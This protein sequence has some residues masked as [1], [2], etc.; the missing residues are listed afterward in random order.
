MVYDIRYINELTANVTPIIEPKNA[1]LRR[2]MKKF[3]II[4][5]CILG[6]TQCGTKTYSLESPTKQYIELGSYGGFAGVSMVYTFLSNGQR[7]KSEGLM[8]A[9]AKSQ[10]LE[11]GDD[12][13]F[14]NMLKE[15]K[16]LDFKNIELNEVG[17][18][19]YFITLKS[20]RKEKKIQWNNM[21]MAPKE[22]VY[23]YRNTL[24]SLKKSA[25]N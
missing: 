25:I 17:N 5:L 3:V 6:L 10:E 14:K 11:K 24:R 16:V 1:Y 12:A 15:M 22:L 21:D 23:F 13:A 9:E 8:G 18:M 4:V 20:K 7:F 19:T 2:R